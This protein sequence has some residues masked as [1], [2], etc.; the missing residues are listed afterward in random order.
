MEKL[1]PSASSNHVHILMSASSSY[2]NSR[3]DFKPETRLTE[4]DQQLVRPPQ[5]REDLDQ[6]GFGP[7]GPEEIFMPDS[8]V[9]VKSSP[10]MRREVL[11]V[12]TI[13]TYHRIKHISIDPYFFA[14]S[15]SSSSSRTPHTTPHHTTPH[16][17][18]KNPTP[19]HQVLLSLGSNPFP[20]ACNHSF[21]LL[22]YSSACSSFKTLGTTANPFSRSCFTCAGSCAPV[23]RSFR[24]EAEEEGRVVVWVWVAIGIV[25]YMYMDVGGR[26]MDVVRDGWY[27]GAIGDD[28]VGDT[29]KE[30]PRTSDIYI[31]TLYDLCSFPNAEHRPPSKIPRSILARSPTDEPYVQTLGGMSSASSPPTRRSEDAPRSSSCVHFLFATPGTATV[32]GILVH[33]G[34][35]EPRTS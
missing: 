15:K 25:G 34:N 9:V 27:S 28:D 12:P 29:M 3:P 26:W 16:P 24:T 7:D 21:A 2:S 6:L 4:R 17:A 11:D 23:A 13:T 32:Y 31:R 20:K 18:S 5:F 30:R 22:T 14:T 35:W 10:V 19:T 1:A 8:K 33:A